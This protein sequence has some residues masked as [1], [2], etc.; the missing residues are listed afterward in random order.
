MDNYTVDTTVYWGSQPP[1]K[2]NRCY[3]RNG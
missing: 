3:L 2:F 1:R